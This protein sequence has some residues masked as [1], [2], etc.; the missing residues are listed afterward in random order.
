MSTMSTFPAPN[1]AHIPAWRYYR[2]SRL[3]NDITSEL[4]ISN[5]GGVQQVYIEFVTENGGHITNKADHI[6]VRNARGDVDFSGGWILFEMSPGTTVVIDIVPS[7][8]RGAQR[9]GRGSGLIQWGTDP[10]YPEAKALLVSG[11]IDYDGK[12]KTPIIVN[13]G[14]AF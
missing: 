3:A 13:G 12:S 10:S 9:Q 7:G 2:P 4:Q 11:H 1:Q 6:K 5:L 14:F 8:M